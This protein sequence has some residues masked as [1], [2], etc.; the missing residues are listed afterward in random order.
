MQEMRTPLVVA[1]TLGDEVLD[2]VR[3][4]LEHGASTMG[5]PSVRQ[6]PLYT[7]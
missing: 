4:L 1:C 7:K 2:V 6:L 3:V 5:D